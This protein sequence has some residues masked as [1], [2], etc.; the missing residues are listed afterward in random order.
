MK[1]SPALYCILLYFFIHA[2][3][4]A[5]TGPKLT[6]DAFE[7]AIA[8][9][10]IQL[11]DVRTQ[12]EYFSGHIEN[13]LL[14]DWN[15][16][17]EFERRIASLDKSRPLY[18]YCLSGGRSAA[19]AAK[20]REMG[21]ENVYEL[22]GGTNA[23]RAA[24]KPLEAE[25][26]EEQM[27]LTAFDA[28]VAGSANLLVNFG[29]SWC[30]PCRQMEPVLEALKSHHGEK[31]TLLKVDGGRDQDIVQA[32]QVVALPVFI[33]FKNGKQVW[34]KEGIATETELAAQ[35]Q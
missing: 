5:Q 7:K 15:D 1:P 35:L 10:E 32:Y 29:A 21:F 28:T 27:T 2:T 11:L 16:R 14:A 20:M 26:V 31:F 22:Q 13:A 33:V 23:W 6:A 12:R 34:R 25:S 3:C 9:H 8:K 24:Q 4:L 17:A 30:P 19:A 18:V